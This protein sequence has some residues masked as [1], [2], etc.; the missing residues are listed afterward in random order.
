MCIKV[1]PVQNRAVLEEARRTGRHNN[2]P[3]RFHLVLFAT[4]H[5]LYS[6]GDA[7]SFFP[8]LGLEQYLGGLAAGKHDKVFPVGIWLEISRERRRPS[9]RSGVDRSG[10]GE[11]AG[12]VSSILNHESKSVKL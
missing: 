7:G 2:L 5:K 9:S 11:E 4:R 6:L 12:G 8:R 3:L 1:P 10:G